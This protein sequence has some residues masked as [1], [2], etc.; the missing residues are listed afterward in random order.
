MFDYYLYSHFEKNWNE[1]VGSK[2]LLACMYVILT[3]QTWRH[4]LVFGPYN[5]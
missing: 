1:M 2:K 4:E 5:W 3:V